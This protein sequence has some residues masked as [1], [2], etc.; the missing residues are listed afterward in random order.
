MIANPDR[1]RHASRG[2]LRSARRIVGQRLVLLLIPRVVVA[3]ALA[4]CGGDGPQQVPT[5]GETEEVADTVTRTRPSGVK[6]R[7]REDGRQ[8]QRPR[9]S[10][11]LLEPT[12]RQT[13]A[14]GAV[15]VSA[16]VTGF[17][18]VDQRVRPPFPPPEA[19]QG[20]VHFYLDTVNLPTTHSPPATGSYRSISGTSY[21]WPDVS[22]G[23]HSFAVQLVGKDHVPLRNPVKDRITLVVR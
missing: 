3:V 23:R 5:P 6:E 15:T 4:A 7:H 19:G 13:V 9:P 2:E 22:P 12:R 11:T 21:T 8:R 1:R 14:A 16:S 17:R 18:L 20:H 10:I